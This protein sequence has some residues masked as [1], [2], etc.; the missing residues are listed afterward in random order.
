M[1]QRPDEGLD[2]ASPKGDSSSRSNRSMVV[3]SL[4]HSKRSNNANTSFT[5]VTVQPNGKNPYHD[6]ENQTIRRNLSSQPN[7]SV[8]GS[9]VNQELGN[10]RTDSK[11]NQLN[12]KTN[13]MVEQGS[14]VNQLS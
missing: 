12:S 13:S 10:V 7:V 2:V 3:P 5:S 11:P 14:P 9:K 4:S 1:T 8:R 6:I